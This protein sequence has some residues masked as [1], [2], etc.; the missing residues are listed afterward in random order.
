MNC[1]RAVVPNKSQ[2]QNT[3]RAAMDM[4]VDFHER[5]NFRGHMVMIGTYGVRQADIEELQTRLEGSTLVPV[6]LFGE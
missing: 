3:L 5:H 2:E 1:V 4:L 6:P